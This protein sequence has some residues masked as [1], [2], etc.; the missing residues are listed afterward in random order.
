MRRRRVRLESTSRPRTSACRVQGSIGAGMHGLE[1]PDRLGELGRIGSRRR[2]RLRY[3]VH[4]DGGSIA[5]IVG[6]VPR[7]DEATQPAEGLARA[8]GLIT[9]G[10]IFAPH[11]VTESRSYRVGDHHRP[12]GFLSVAGC[13][14]LPACRT[15]SIGTRS[16][17]RVLS[18]RWPA[19]PQ[20][21]TENPVYPL[22][23]RFGQL[24][25]VQEHVR[26]NDDPH[27]RPV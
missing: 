16:C 14:G 20:I 17:C 8:R 1:Q 21:D 27:V 18:S 7:V 25:E 15:C 24:A 2:M 23:A 22:A 26:R 3:R 11:R 5:G 19:A 6:G 12:A 9:P 10:T 4:Q 13:T